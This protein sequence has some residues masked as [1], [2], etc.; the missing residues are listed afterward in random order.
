ME[1]IA[2][3]INQ[4][5]CALKEWF[6]YKTVEDEVGELTRA[7]EVYLLG[8]IGVTY[9]NSGEVTA[10]IDGVFPIPPNSF[11][12]SANPD[13]HTYI[14]SHRIS[15]DTADTFGKNTGTNQRLSYIVKKYA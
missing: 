4:I 14:K 12:T 15:F 7:D 8:R 9:Q 13:R 3:Y 11:F 6:N 2:K 10:I 5:Y 1:E